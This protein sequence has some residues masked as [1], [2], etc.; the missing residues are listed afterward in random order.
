MVPFQIC[1]A[2][3]HK[4]LVT[5]FN[6]HSATDLKAPP[7]AQ[8]TFRLISDPDFWY[9]HVFFFSPLFS[10][11]LSMFVL[12]CHAHEGDSAYRNLNVFCYCTWLCATWSSLVC[13]WRG[14][15]RFSTHLTAVTVNNPLICKLIEDNKGIVVM[16]DYLCCMTAGNS[17]QLKLTHHFPKFLPTKKFCNLDPLLS[18][19]HE[20]LHLFLWEKVSWSF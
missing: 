3:W 6:D 1:S 5:L 12:L 15:Q 11:L 16:S 2:V 7:R 20:D 13:V 14:C 19:R 8:F 10:C 4:T 17:D 18:T 9:F